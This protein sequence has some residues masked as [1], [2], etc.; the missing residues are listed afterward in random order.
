M[1]QNSSDIHGRKGHEPDEI[2]AEEARAEHQGTDADSPWSRETLVV[3][4]GRPEREHDA[5]VN[6]PIVLSS[7]FHGAGPI[8]PED[9]AYG[10]FTSPTW[11]DLEQV[12]SSLEGSE[13]PALLFGS[14]MGAVAGVVGQVPV[15]SVIVM[16][17]H[18]YL[19]SMSLV[20]QME[21]RGVCTLVEVAI[22]DTDRVIEVLTEQARSLPEPA[23]GA[24]APYVLFWLESPTNP[25]LE[26]ADL[27]TLLAA[28]RGLGIRT[29]VDNTF[30]TPLVQR[31]LEWGADFVVHSATKYLAGHSDVVMGAVVTRDP[32]L[33][34]ATLAQRSLGGAIAGPVEAWLALRGLR[35]LSLRIRQSSASAQVLAERL[36]DHPAVAEVRYPGLP[37]DRGHDRAKAQMSNFG[38]VLSATVDADAETT[39]RVVEALRL[40]TPATSLGGVESLVERRRRHS[41]EAP[42][43]SEAL[44]RLSVGIEDV[45][46]LWSDLSQ[47][48]D[49][50]EKR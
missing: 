46:D 24:E 42:S 35:T 36:R 33:R 50:V 12:L 23:P 3:S 2:V 22:E 49:H 14:G 4:A 28:A 26:V 10:R 39:Q 37:E 27:P 5:P 32:A 41:N 20:R 18:T 13:L 17:E 8:L 16:P 1:Q 48:L 15:G 7:T 31:P 19:G 44:L 40:W 11:E 47:A 29:A 6:S 25:M 38:S 45:E 21:R 43:V 9:R 30:A 34:E